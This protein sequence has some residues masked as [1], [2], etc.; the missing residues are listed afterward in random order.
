[1]PNILSG[2][3][4][5]PTQTIKGAIFGPAQIFAG[6]EKQALINKLDV[7]HL[8][9]ACSPKP[10]THLLAG[11]LLSFIISDI[12]V[13][14]YSGKY[15]SA[16]QLTIVMVLLIIIIVVFIT[17]RHFKSNIMRFFHPDAHDVLCKLDEALA[18]GPI[19]Y[20]MMDDN[21]EDN[22]SNQHGVGDQ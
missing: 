6:V 13:D 7:H 16:L 18:G 4:N 19:G 20:V 21:M 11:G 8:R 3:S 22:S 17:E 14:V 15:P 9:S 2:H 12:M 5:L 10:F 1:M